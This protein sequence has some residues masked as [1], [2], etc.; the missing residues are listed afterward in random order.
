MK[1]SSFLDNLDC[2][3]GRGGIL[4]FKDTLMKALEMTITMVGISLDAIFLLEYSTA[5]K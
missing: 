4:H 2:D 1:F 5:S 3:V